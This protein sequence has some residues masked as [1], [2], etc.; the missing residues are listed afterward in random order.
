MYSNILWKFRT[1]KN[2]DQKEKRE[3]KHARKEEPQMIQ[4]QQAQGSLRLS[5]NNNNRP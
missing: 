1:Q 4:K 5:T 2:F 3:K